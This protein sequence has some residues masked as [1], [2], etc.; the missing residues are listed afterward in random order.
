MLKM[1]RDLD[2]SAGI[3]GRSTMLHLPKGTV[4]QFLAWERDPGNE[5]R[6][7]VAIE[8][9]WQ[10]YVPADALVEEN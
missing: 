3:P 9:G 5:G 8:M 1:N 10:G 4:V 2:V 6:A 7:L